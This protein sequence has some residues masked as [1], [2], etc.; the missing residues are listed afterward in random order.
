MRIMLIAEPR[1]GSTSLGKYFFKVKPKYSVYL[2]PFN[3]LKH[4][5]IPYSDV[6]KHDDCFIKQLYKQIPSEYNNI[7]RYEFYDIVFNDFDKIVFL[8][9]KNL[10]KQSESFSSALVS[11]KWEGQYMYDEKKDSQKL[12]L[13]LKVL[14]DVKNEMHQLAEIKQSKIFYYEDLFYNKENMLKFLN[15]IECPYNERYFN[16]YLDISKKYRGEKN[17]KVLI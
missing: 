16:D 15:E 14:Q 11:D 12:E 13:S 1:T 7:T 6:L 9:R 2:E 8:S 5:S 10:E 3:I 17:T 4:E